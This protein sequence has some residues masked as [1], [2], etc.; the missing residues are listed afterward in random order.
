MLYKYNYANNN[1]QEFTGGHPQID[2]I[3][4]IP[5]LAVTSNGEPVFSCSSYDNILGSDVVMKHNNITNTWEYIN[6][7]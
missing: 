6:C 4:L 3:M 5:T 1:W 7:Q 2:Y